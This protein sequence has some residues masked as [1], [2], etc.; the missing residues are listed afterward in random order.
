MPAS[1]RSSSRAAA[2]SRV[3]QAAAAMQA[4]VARDRRGATAWRWSG[5]NCMGVIDLTVNKAT[6]HRRCL[7]LPAARRRRRHRAVGLRH[8]RV[9]PIGIAG[10]LQPDHQLRVRGRPRRLRLP[11]VLP[12]RPRDD[13]GHPV[14]RGVPSPGA[15]PGA[16]RPRARA[17]QAD[18][19]RQGRPER[20]GARRSDRPFRV[21]RGRG[22]RDRCRPRCG[23]RDPL[24]RPRRAARD[25]RARRGHPADGP[26][27]RS[28][29]D[30][31][32]D[33][34][35]RRGVAHRRSRAG[36]GPRPAAD[37]RARPRR[38]SS[39][40]LPTMGFIGNPL[41]PWGAA[42]ATT[43]YGVGLRGHGGVRR[44]RRARPG[45]RL[46][47]SSRWPPRSPPPTR[48]PA[49]CSMRRATGRDCCRSTSRSRP[50]SRR[51]RPRPSS[52]SRAA[53]RRCF[54]APTRPSGRSAPWRAG[55]RRHAARRVRGP[56]RADWPALAARPIGLR[57]RRRP[58]LPAEHT[59]RL[60]RS[61]S[62]T[63][64]SCCAMPGWP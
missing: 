9:R 31:R 38:R 26:R 15:V 61:A 58:P 43:A 50:A 13:V 21:A 29:P 27:H 45:P 48:S 36:R 41:D 40:R 6:L 28:W 33:G 4:E 63:A 20:A 52:M 49:R 32:R 57:P 64:S 16:G 1:Q 54:A 5:P 44:L 22:P 51:P 24:R 60:G 37:P 42:D 25:R 2:W 17:R 46:P 10:R 19:G 8:R 34:Q 53:E 12:R 23:R 35:H 55:Q 3:A 56:W 14:P 30:G 7:A 62:A 18:H 39:R 47:L 59:H 11:R